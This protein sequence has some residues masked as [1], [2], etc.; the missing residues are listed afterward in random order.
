MGFDAIW[1][2]P[3]VDNFPCG[4]H[5]YWARSKF[6]V[7]QQFGG[8]DELSALLEECHGRGMAVML[9]IVVS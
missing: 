1:I 7:E 3:I 2:S 6:D 5:G 4:Y 8:A 9:D